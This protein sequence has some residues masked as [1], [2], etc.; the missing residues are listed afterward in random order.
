[1]AK[2]GPQKTTVTQ[3]SIPE[4]AQPY[5]ENL[6]K[7]TA[8][9]SQRAYEP[10]QGQRLANINPAVTS[11]QSFVGGLGFNP[12]YDN[13]M[14]LASGAA[15]G[16]GSSPYS[17]YGFG[18]LQDFRNNVGSYMSPYM[19]NVVDV[20]KAQAQLD[21]DRAQAARDAAA[22]QS[23][24]FGGSRSAVV[25]ALAQEDLARRM[26]EIQATGL[27][28]AFD[29]ASGAFE[30]QRRAGMDLDAQRAADWARVQQ[31]MGD[32]GLA[33]AG[34]RSDIAGRMAGLADAQLGAQGG[35]YDL[36]NQA[37]RAAMAD[38]QASLDVGYQDF[39]S[40]MNYP[41][42]QLAFY[43]SILQGIPVQPNTQTMYSTNTN[44]W[45]EM[46]GTGL[47][48]LGTYKYLTA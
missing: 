35:Y 5:F 42:D 12:A 37:G 6:L 18:P 46:L 28:S 45:Q 44:P 33:S 14:S 26:G 29:S 15:A 4:Y 2:G 47:S 3:T 17:G 8:F 16:L 41:R 43:S 25:N 9:E 20:Q 11:A 19:Q 34:L 24:A 7:D 31:G 13:A 40:Q 36:M 1:M 38:Q 30:N 48:A 39:L 22:V 21:F 23:G 10:Y 32:Y 27:Q